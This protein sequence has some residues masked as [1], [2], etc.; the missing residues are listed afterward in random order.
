[1][2]KNLWNKVTPKEG[3]K[4]LG[5]DR[6]NLDVAFRNLTRLTVAKMRNQLVLTVITYSERTHFDTEFELCYV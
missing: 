5:V 3:Q 6:N 4:K 1:M 2:G